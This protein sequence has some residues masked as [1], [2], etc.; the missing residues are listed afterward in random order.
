MDKYMKNKYFKVILLTLGLI[1]ATSSMSRA[2]YP[3]NSGRPNSNSVSYEDVYLHKVTSRYTSDTTF[4]IYIRADE[5]MNFI[6]S[7]RPVIYSALMKNGNEYVDATITLHDDDGTGT[8]E[9]KIVV[10]GLDFSSR[11]FFSWTD[12]EAMGKTLFENYSYS[13]RKSNSIKFL[14][15]F[16]FN[17]GRTLVGAVDTN[18]TGWDNLDTAIDAEEEGMRWDKYRAVVFTSEVVAAIASTLVR[19][20]VD[21]DILIAQKWANL[22]DLKSKITLHKRK[23]NKLTYPGMTSAHQ[24]VITLETRLNTEHKAMAATAQA[25]L[26][27]FWDDQETKTNEVYSVAYEAKQ[28]MLEDDS[29]I[30]LLES[31]LA[32][33][34]LQTNL[35]NTLK[36]TDEQRQI[37]IGHQDNY[38][39]YYRALINA[40]VERATRKEV[41]RQARE[42]LLIKAVW[43]VQINR[44]NERISEAQNALTVATN[45]IV[46][47]DTLPSKN[48]Y[49]Q[50]LEQA[51]IGVN[52]ALVELES[53]A[54]PIT[55]SQSVADGYRSTYSLLLQDAVALRA[56]YVAQL[57]EIERKRLEDEAWDNQKRKVE[58]ALTIANNA[59][60]QAGSAMGSNADL[61]AKLTKIN[62]SMA[63]NSSLLAEIKKFQALKRTDA[64]GVIA[65]S[66]NQQYQTLLSS[67]ATL[68]I[69]YVEE[70]RI[71]DEAA[72]VEEATLTGHWKFPIIK[73]L[74]YATAT[75][76]GV[77]DESGAFKCQPGETVDFSIE[78]LTLTSMPCTEILGTKTTNSVAIANTSGGNF[79]DWQNEP[80]KQMAIT[81]VL[82]GL[83]GESIKNAFNQEDESLK[84]I[85]VDLTDEQKA[86]TVG[87]SLEVNDLSLLVQSIL[88][89][90]EAAVLLTTEQADNMI[91][92][93]W[94]TSKVFDAGNT[95]NTVNG[96]NTINTVNGGNTD[97][98]ASKKSSGGGGC[99]YNP[100]AKGSSDIGFIFLFVLSTYYLIRRKRL[101]IK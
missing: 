59:L 50:A 48:A 54:R 29:K 99:V 84:I 93:G 68:M 49:I 6:T 13:Q 31:T 35:L 56:N 4:E 53:L 87:E 41:Q 88:G 22:E 51:N 74:T 62:D 26:V 57:A 55:V 61:S 45:E 63:S 77:T 38:S 46:K 36:Y 91:V 60:I 14:R 65:D 92:S 27:A 69:S 98:G 8:D 89:T 23:I 15:T 7:A 9:I 83:F 20:T 32:P 66:F 71:A 96:G 24:S 43:E 67:I 30:E 73:G 16:Q 79:K 76:S 12:M 101:A 25:K 70:K 11:I 81:K 34:L 18:N 44:V 85:T 47:P 1:F 10:S 2:S 80:D 100:D 52:D 58:A 64:D 39:A 40:K 33:Y 94:Q 75:Y 3:Y 28:Q 37:V 5:N 95:I 97:T 42:T 21:T 17:S 78:S 72:A 86:N 90:T 19:D 82:F